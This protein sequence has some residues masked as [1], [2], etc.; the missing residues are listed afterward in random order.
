MAP[1]IRDAAEAAGGSA[2]L[3][4]NGE[5]AQKP[6]VAVVVFGETPYAEGQGDI[7]TLAYDAGDSAELE[8]MHSMKKQ[9]IPVV[10][11]FLTGR[12][13]WVNAEIN[14]ADAFVVAWLPGSEGAG[15]ADVIMGDAQG[16]ARYEPS[17]QGH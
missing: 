8:L 12:P 2:T 9:G 11:L 5:F 16:E 15:V 13:M 4:V 6:D 10:A 7:E 17:A 1:G 3:S 14:V